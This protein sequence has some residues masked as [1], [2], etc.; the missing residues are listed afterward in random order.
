MLADMA[1]SEMGGR[2]PSVGHFKF[3]TPLWLNYYQIKFVIASITV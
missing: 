3:L 2:D 1:G